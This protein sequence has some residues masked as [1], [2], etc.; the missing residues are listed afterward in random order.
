MGVTEGVALDPN[1]EAVNASRSALATNLELAPLEKV[2]T[3]GSRETRSPEQQFKESVERLNKCDRA[4][5]K[6]R[7]VRLPKQT[8]DAATKLRYWHS[9]LQGA[10]EE[11]KI[12]FDERNR[13]IEKTVSPGERGCHSGRVL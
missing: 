4:V 1:S 13:A 6:E 8:Q 3:P 7:H 9:K 10:E 11:R 2:F 5:K 12:A